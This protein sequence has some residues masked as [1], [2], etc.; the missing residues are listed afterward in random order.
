MMAVRIFH[1]KPGAEVPALKTATSP[2][3]PLAN[4]SHPIRVA[5]ANVAMPGAMIAAAP[6]KIKA[7]PYIKNQVVYLCIVSGSFGSPAGMVA[8]IQEKL[9]AVR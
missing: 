5:A 3:V 9:T 2:I 1:E 6:N 4:K 8:S 7:M